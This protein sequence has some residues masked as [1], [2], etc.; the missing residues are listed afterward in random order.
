MKHQIK[1]IRE[2]TKMS[3]SE[4]A[5]AYN[6]P[7]STLRKWEQLVSIPPQYVIDLL[8]Q[9]IPAFNNDLTK[10]ICDDNNVYYIDK[11]NKKI[12]D[13]KRNCISFNEPIDDVIEAN[14][15]VYVK[16]LFD[17]FYKIQNKFDRDLLLDKKEK[18]IWR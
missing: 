6:I 1:E 7:L 17:D 15:P 5:K 8:E 2:A 10:V 3:Q 14:L 18:I 16:D 13:N 11:E 4:F 9:S 12:F